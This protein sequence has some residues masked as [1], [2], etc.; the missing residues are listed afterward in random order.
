MR[1]HYDNQTKV[2]IL[3]YVKLFE[4][5]GAWS[6]ICIAAFVLEY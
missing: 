3:I 6:K 4:K 5:L 2:Q 1:V